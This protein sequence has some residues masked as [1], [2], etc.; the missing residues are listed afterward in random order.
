MD[1]NNLRFQPAKDV[2]VA[3]LEGEIV[4]YSPK[5]AKGYHLNETAAWIWRH[6]GE[7]GGLP[8]LVAKMSEEFDC[9]LVRLQT[10]VERVVN[11]M[12]AA[13]LLV[14]CGNDLA[15]E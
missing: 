11:E 2:T 3:E 5:S 15:E 4:A 10:D 12:A 8:A 14:K 7:C 9:D 1:P 13:G 6:S